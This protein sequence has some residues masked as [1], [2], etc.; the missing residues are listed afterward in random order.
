MYLAT[1]SIQLSSSFRQAQQKK[2]S[3]NTTPP[4]Q[5]CSQPIKHLRTLSGL[6]V[7][8]HGVIYECGCGSS[9]GLEGKLDSIK[10]GHGTPYPVHGTA[11]GDEVPTHSP[12]IDPGDVMHANLTCTEWPAYRN[13][14]LDLMAH[15]FFFPAT[16][17]TADGDGLFLR[18]SS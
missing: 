14:S 8:A 12:L 7:P 11:L 5:T 2:K 1:E 9:V 16:P 17:G 3:I 18:S 15:C 6:R 13:V 4:C 10:Q